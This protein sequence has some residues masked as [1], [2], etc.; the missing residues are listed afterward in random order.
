MDSE[1]VLRGVAQLPPE[2]SRPNPH[3]KPPVS[4]VPGR[5]GACGQSNACRS[6][7]SLLL[8]CALATLPDAGAAVTFGLPK[9]EAPTVSTRQRSRGSIRPM[10]APSGLVDSLRQFQPIAKQILR[11][12]LRVHRSRARPLPRRAASQLGCDQTPVTCPWRQI[13][14]LDGTLQSVRCQAIRAA[15]RNVRKWPTQDTGQDRSKTNSW[16]SCDSA[17]D[18][19]P[20]LHIDDLRVLLD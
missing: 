6:R 13:K 20:S 10:L 5:I 7:P 14:R 18:A 19:G 8:L 4:I 12:H 15:Q 17:G 11:G 3:H 1:S 9:S 16:A 2:H